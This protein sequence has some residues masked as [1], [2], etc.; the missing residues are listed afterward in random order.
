M[1]IGTDAVPWL[2][3]AV[4]HLMPRYMIMM[5]MM[6]LMLILI[7]MILMYFMHIFSHQ[8][9]YMMILKNFERHYQ[10]NRAPFGLFYHPAW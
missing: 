9:V 7:M 3:L 6:M 10:T 5:M 1:T 8:G 4:I 2:T